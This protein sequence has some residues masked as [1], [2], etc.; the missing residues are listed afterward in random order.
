MAHGRL[1][2]SSTPASSSAR[3]HPRQHLHDLGTVLVA[4][5]L[6]PVDADEPAAPG[7]QRPL[8][9]KLPALAGVGQVA[10]QQGIDALVLLPEAAGPGRFCIC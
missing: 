8:G 10:V 1:T 3:R 7:V 6:P 5:T 9:L 4:L 2:V